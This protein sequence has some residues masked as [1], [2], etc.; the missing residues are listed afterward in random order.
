MWIAK[1]KRERDAIEIMNKK[2]LKK[3]FTLTTAAEATLEASKERF[4]TVRSSL[5]P[6]EFARILMPF[7]FVETAS[8]IPSLLNRILGEA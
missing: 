3:T 4:S 7:S 1:A 5:I 2:I 8:N 6:S